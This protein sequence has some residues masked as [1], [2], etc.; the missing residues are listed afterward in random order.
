MKRSFVSLRL[1]LKSIEG[2]HRDSLSMAYGLF[3]MRM[4]CKERVGR[5][6]HAHISL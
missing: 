3:C 4:L 1:I 2:S 5:V 6:G